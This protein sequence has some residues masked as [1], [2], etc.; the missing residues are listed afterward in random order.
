MYDPRQIDFVA[1]PAQMTA[2]AI[3]DIRF[4]ETASLD[5]LP[6]PA[7]APEGSPAGSPSGATGRSG[8]SPA[9]GT[10]RQR[11]RNGIVTVAV[12]T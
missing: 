3:V 6:E 7:S 4:R 12:T 8:E 5:D 9:A 1:L 10:L 11:V 2:H